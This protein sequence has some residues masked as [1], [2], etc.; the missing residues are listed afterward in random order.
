MELPHGLEHALTHFGLVGRVGR[1]ELAACDELEDS[2]GDV[3][4]VQSSTQEGG[5]AAHVSVGTEQ[6]S[7]IADDLLFRLRTWQWKLAFE[8]H[9]VRNIREQI[10]HGSEPH[11]L[12]H[13]GFS[14]SIG[15][16]VNHGTH[17]PYGGYGQIHARTA[18][19]ELLRPT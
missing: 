9:I 4:S 16:L 17:T 14:S 13:F 10:L 15:Q 12:Q 8:T 2:G 6:A 11:F 3:V 5:S 18:H 19:N 1:E 7:R